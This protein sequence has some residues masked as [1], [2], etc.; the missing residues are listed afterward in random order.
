MLNKKIIS[1]SICIVLL[2]AMFSGCV[3]EQADEVKIEYPQ[4]TTQYLNI[5]IRSLGHA[6]GFSDPAIG[7]T[8]WFSRR[9]GVYE[10]LIGL[11]HD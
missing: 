1:L 3:E 7:W 8:G 6:D 11:D 9:I 4:D 10:N 5:G 2:G